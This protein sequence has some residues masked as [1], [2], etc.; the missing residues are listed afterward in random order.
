MSLKPK[1]PAGSGVRCGII[2]SAGDGA[3]LREFVYRQWGHYLP[4]QYLNFVGARSLLE[5]T[6]HRVEKLIP[7]RRLFVVIAREHL[8]FSEVR[9][10]ISTRPAGTVVIQPV[11][12]ETGPGILLPLMRVYKRHPDAAVAIFPSDHF[13]RHEDLFVAYLDQAFRAVESDPSR[14]VLLGAEPD[15]PDPE[16]GY[17]V[18]GQKVK[19]EDLN[20]ARKVEMFVEKPAVEVARKIIRSSALWNTL[21][22]VFRCQT[23]V[24]VIRRTL[25]DLYRSFLPVLQA[26]GRPEERRVIEQAYRELQPIDFSQGVLEA[27]P[28]EQ[29]QSL[30]V[31]PMRGVDW[32]DWGSTDRLLRGLTKLGALGH[33]RE[34]REASEERR[35]SLLP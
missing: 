9:R 30:L 28:L 12:K 2:L 3:R 31:L 25:P 21:V 15:E 10:Q 7:A 4:K 35:L 16:Y 27:L 26:I 13:I 18:P 23:L 33:L 6:F 1:D 8:R 34:E 5:H 14:I 29:R 19:D 24:D 11:N 32:S 22:I 20:G 17:I